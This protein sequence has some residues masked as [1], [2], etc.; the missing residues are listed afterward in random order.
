MAAEQADVV[1]D[2]LDL[3]GDVPVDPTISRIHEVTQ[4]YG[5]FL[6]YSWDSWSRLFRERDRRP[7]AD[8]LAASMRA[9]CRG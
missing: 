9:V 7:G 4:V 8:A 5:K 3:D 1:V 2:L 6:P